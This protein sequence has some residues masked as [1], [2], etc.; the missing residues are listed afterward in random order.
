MPYELNSG[1][2]VSRLNRFGADV[3]LRTVQGPHDDPSHYSAHDLVA[4]AN[5]CAGTT[6]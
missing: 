6:D 5:E 2:I 1:E 4:F 3:S